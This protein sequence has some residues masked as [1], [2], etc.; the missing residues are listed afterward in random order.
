MFARLTLAGNKNILTPIGAIS[1]QFFHGPK[2]AKHDESLSIILGGPMGPIHK[3]SVPVLVSSV[4]VYMTICEYFQTYYK[5][6]Y[7]IF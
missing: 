7:H 1:G 6:K 5:S 2:H 3:V 4:A